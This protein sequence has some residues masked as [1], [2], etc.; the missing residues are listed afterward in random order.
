MT[1]PKPTLWLTV[2]VCSICQEADEEE[3]EG[4]QQPRKPFDPGEDEVN[5]E[6][7]REDQARLPRVKSDDNRG[8]SNAFRASRAVELGSFA[9][10][11][12]T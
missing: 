1:R 6:D 10:T 8:I 5:D 3:V 11:Y 9:A 2:L 12:R 7:G 4:E